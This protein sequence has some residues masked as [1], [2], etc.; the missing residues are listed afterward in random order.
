[1]REYIETDLLAALQAGFG[2]GCQNG[3]IIDL[4]RGALVG[5]SMGGHGVLT[6][7]S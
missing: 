7:V 6:M 5:H 3:A 1:M 4:S 2:A